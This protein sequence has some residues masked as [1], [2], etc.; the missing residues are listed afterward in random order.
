MTYLLVTCKALGQSPLWP[1]QYRS[2]IKS[3]VLLYSSDSYNHPTKQLTTISMSTNNSTKKPHFVNRY[4]F[5]NTELRTATIT[6]I[7]GLSIQTQQNTFVLFT[8]FKLTLDERKTLTKISTCKTSHNHSPNQ[9]TPRTTTKVQTAGYTP[10]RTFQMK[11]N[12]H[13]AICITGDSAVCT[14]PIYGIQTSIFIC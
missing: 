4:C 7:K 12:Q 2:S 5:C 6:K 11:K 13:S 9:R 8:L 10:R 1:D 3:P 14:Q